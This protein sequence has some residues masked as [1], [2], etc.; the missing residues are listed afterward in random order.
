MPLKLSAWTQKALTPMTFWAWPTPNRAGLIGVLIDG[1]PAGLA[2]AA[3]DFTADLDRR[4]PGATGT[5]M[6]REPD[7]P[8]IRSGCFNGRTTG[9][10][11]LVAFANTDVRPDDYAA[12]ADLPRPGH[13]DFTARAKFGGFQDPRGGGHF[14][15][16]LTAALVAAGTVAKKILAPIS[17]KA[18]LLEAGGSPDIETA[19]QNALCD[20]DSTGGLVECRIRRPVLSP[21]SLYHP[22][23]GVAGR[24]RSFG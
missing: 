9:A 11:L 22:K 3:E 16:R 8:L 24:L 14:S 18:S 5:T 20:G 21:G 10:P 1:C 4:R 19:V 13:A 7:K 15:G 17:F 2:L 23:R 12:F 6:R